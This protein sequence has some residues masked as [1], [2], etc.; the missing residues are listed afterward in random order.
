MTG[1]AKQVRK[2]LVY[3]FGSPLAP[4]PDFKS[5]VPDHILSEAW[6]VTRGGPTSNYRAA[7]IVL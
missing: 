2:D 3:G 6:K 7:L 4:D 5:R 1:S